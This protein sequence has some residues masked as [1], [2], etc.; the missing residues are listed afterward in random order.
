M[1]A[2]SGGVDSAVSA[3]L[4]LSQG[5]QVEAAFM[6]NWSK[7]TGLLLS[8][9]PWLEDRRDAL[10]MAA[11]LGIPL[12]TFD[13]EREYSDKVMKYFFEEYAAG[14][15]PNPDVMCNKEI[16]FKLLYNAAMAAGFDYLATGHYAQIKLAAKTSKFAKKNSGTAKLIRSK[17]EFKDQTYFIYN[18]AAEQLDHI[19][20]P[21][22]GYKK[23]E[24]RALAKKLKLPNAE[25]KES[26]GICFVGKIR[27]EEF[28]RQKLAAKPGN[29]VDKSGK[30]LGRHEGTSF[31]TLGQRNGLNIGG[32]GPYYVVRKNIAKNLLVVSS[33][34]KDKDLEVKEIQ[35]EA[36][37]WIDKPR[38]FPV[39]LKCRFRHQQKLLDVTLKEVNGQLIAKFSKVQ[40]AIASGQSVVFYKNR[41][42]LGGGIIQ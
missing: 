33:D 25:R 14:R 8:E 7:T 16:K 39:K 31:Y 37:H 13:F 18:L 32:G 27:L 19:L 23:N 3:A 30:V 1:V 9:C 17:D 4:L 2:L 41:E 11:Y 40:H 10:R 12:R 20:F 15:T 22:G 28:L 38:K 6:K 5:F 42:C 36:A 35:V 34:P 24:V 26:M 21:I 29:I